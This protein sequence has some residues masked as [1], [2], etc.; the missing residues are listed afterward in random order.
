MTSY[1]FV[2][3][4]Y[5]LGEQKRLLSKTIKNQNYDNDAVFFLNIISCCNALSFVIYF[6]LRL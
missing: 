5:S 4:K 6:I 1:H 2:L 3:Y